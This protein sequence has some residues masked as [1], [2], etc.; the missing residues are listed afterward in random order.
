MKSRRKTKPLAKN[1]IDVAVVAQ[2]NDETAWEKPVRVRRTRKASISLTAETAAR[3]AFFA[4][5]HRQAS[6][7]AWLRQ[8][9]EERLNM[10]EAALAGVKKQ[11]MQN[12]S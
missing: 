10:E 4:R 1:E 6:A 12:A 11:L 3:A 8:V 9:I 2:S 7:E 5:M